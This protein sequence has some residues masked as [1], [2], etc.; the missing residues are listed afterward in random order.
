MSTDDYPLITLHPVADARHRWSALLVQS[1]NA[2]DSGAFA[3][4]LGEF[5]LLEAL[6]PLSCILPL[7]PPAVLDPQTGDLLPA[8]K[9]VLWLPAAHCVA[10]TLATPLAGL[11]AQGFHMLAAGQLPADAALPPAVTGLALNPADGLDIAA[12][13]NRMPHLSGPHLALGIDDMTSYDTAIKSGFR[14][15]AGNYPLHPLPAKNLVGSPGRTVMLKLLAQITGDADSREIEKTLKQDPNLSYQ[16]L[17]LVNSVSFSLTA[18]I[19]S[20]TQAITLLGRRQLQRWLQLLLYAQPH[21]HGDQASPLMPRAA[22]RAGLMEGLA[23]A[24][25]EGKDQQ[26]RAFMVGIF[27]LLEVMV[28]QPAAEVITPLN[29]SE[30]VAA[31]LLARQGRLGALLTLVEAAESGPDARTR[32]AL[33]AAGLTAAAWAAEQAQACHWAVQVSREA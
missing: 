9:V 19:S 20:F 31:A 14:W 30:E 27:S 22:M 24:C 11:R 26:D 18:K 23:K 4:L 2:D 8:D 33:A 6:G 12:A 13:T 25:G 5:G 17:K 10:P 21:D 15:V 32:D 1:D 28:G 16:L 7:S 3:R 29:L